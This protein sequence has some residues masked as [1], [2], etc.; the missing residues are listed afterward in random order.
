M[1]KARRAEALGADGLLVLTPY[2]NKANDAGMEAH[3]LAVAEAVKTPILLYNVPSRTGCRI[4]LSVLRRL[5][6]HPNIVGIKEASGE[7]S[8]MTDVA[9]LL[10]ENFAMWSGNDDMVLPALALGA[11]GVISVLSN[12]FPSQMHGMTARFFA[13]D[14]A[15]ARALQLQYLPLIRALFSEV[16]PIPI[17]AAMNARGFGVGGYRLPLCEMGEEQRTRL[18]AAL[19]HTEP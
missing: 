9:A 19:R 5:A 13:G 15:G 3:F 16:N 11:S 1:K 10:S 14:T 18:L 6:E 17:K 8:Y 2:Y 4:S 12:L 7:L